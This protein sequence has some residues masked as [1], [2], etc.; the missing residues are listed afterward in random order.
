[1]EQIVL[2]ETH[3]VNL[4]MQNIVY[5]QRLDHVFG[6]LEFVIIMIDVKMH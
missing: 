3:A 4:S 2:L 6:L 1:M 5:H